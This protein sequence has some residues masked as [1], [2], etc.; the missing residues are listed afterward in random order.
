MSA[1]IDERIHCN[2]CN[3]SGSA[4]WIMGMDICACWA[5]VKGAEL[6]SLGWVKGPYMPRRFPLVKNTSA[7]R[8]NVR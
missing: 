1:L 2:A 5:C 3:D 8:T 4:P 7:E 6:Q